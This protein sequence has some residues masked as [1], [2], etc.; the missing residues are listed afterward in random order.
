M[1]IA[2]SMGTSYAQ[3]GEGK[4][5]TTIARVP[6]HAATSDERV[7]V[8]CSQASEYAS[9]L[10]AG[11]LVGHG[12]GLVQG[13]AGMHAYLTGWKIRPGETVPESL[14]GEVGDATTRAT[15]EWF[16]PA[17]RWGVY[18]LEVETICREYPDA[19]I[20]EVLVAAMEMVRATV[21]GEADE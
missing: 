15:E 16:L 9:F 17:V 6:I 8:A 20:R 7:A 13:A 11:Y 4:L 19:D 12:T 1:L 10:V 21:S 14:A 2:L 5:L 3:L 18:S